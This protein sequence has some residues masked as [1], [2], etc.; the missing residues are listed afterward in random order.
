MRANGFAIMEKA[1]CIEC[2]LLFFGCG[3][4]VVLAAETEKQQGEK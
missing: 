3:A 2:G 1:I 4:H